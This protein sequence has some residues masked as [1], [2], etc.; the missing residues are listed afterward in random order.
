MYRGNV[1]GITQYL[2]QYLKNQFFKYFRGS[3][4]SGIEPNVSSIHSMVSAVTEQ[5]ATA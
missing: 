5:P 4:E 1:M 3:M 2:T